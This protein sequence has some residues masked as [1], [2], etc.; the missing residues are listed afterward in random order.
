MQEKR[1]RH[2]FQFSAV[3]HGIF[4]S[5][6]TSFGV[7]LPCLIPRFTGDSE[8]RIS[9]H[10]LLLAA[11]ALVRGLEKLPAPRLPYLAVAFG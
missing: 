9:R 5:R 3:H 6:G 11:F 10:R 4:V 7:H 2:L 1:V 8:R